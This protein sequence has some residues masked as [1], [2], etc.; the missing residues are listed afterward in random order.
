MQKLQ[1]SLGALIIANTQRLMNLAIRSALSIP[2]TVLTMTFISAATTE[3]A[4]SQ[5]KR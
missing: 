4:P 3:K 1:L 2:L 5:I